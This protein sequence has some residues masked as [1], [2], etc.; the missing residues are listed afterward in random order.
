MQNNFIRKRRSRTKAETLKAVSL[1]ALFLFSFIF[2]IG[3]AS[4]LTIKNVFLASQKITIN[5]L[6]PAPLDNFLVV[7]DGSYYYLY[8][9]IDTYDNDKKTKE[10][11]KLNKTKYD[12]TQQKSYYQNDYISGCISV[13]CPAD[14]Q[15]SYDVYHDSDMY[16]MCLNNCQMLCQADQQFNIDY[17]DSEINST[18]NKIK[19]IDKIK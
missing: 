5:A 4:A 17:I 14:C 11:D 6:L 13:G 19:D 1:S 18:D 12:L 2:L 8:K 10:K 3:S 16:S 9:Y 15:V 7:K